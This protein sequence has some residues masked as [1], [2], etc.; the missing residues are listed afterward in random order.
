[1]HFSCVQSIPTRA[2][3][4]SGFYLHVFTSVYVYLYQEA[5]RN[6]IILTVVQVKAQI[7]FSFKIQSSLKDKDLL[8]LVCF[9]QCAQRPYL[10]FFGYLQ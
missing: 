5:F 3:E 2:V 8:M 10:L 9:S 4:G 1:M 6:I 7:D